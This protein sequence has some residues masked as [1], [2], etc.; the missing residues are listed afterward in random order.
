MA[1]HVFAHAQLEEEQMEE[2][3]STLVV[4]ASHRTTKY[5]YNDIENNE[6]CI[7]IITTYLYLY[8]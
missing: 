8:N 3:M 4:S 1:E 6:I 5:H 2:P 7:S